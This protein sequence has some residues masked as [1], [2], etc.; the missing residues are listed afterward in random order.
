MYPER[1]V[2]RFATYFGAAA[3]IAS[4]RPWA[5]VALG[6][7]GAL[8]VQKPVRRAWTRARPGRSVMA[9]TMVPGLTAFLDAA[10]M[11]GYVKGVMRRRARGRR[12]PVSE[13]LR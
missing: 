10:K 1:H 7:A 6:A 3:A 4:R 12:K 9:A 11:A 2:L 13:P 8:Y 5:L